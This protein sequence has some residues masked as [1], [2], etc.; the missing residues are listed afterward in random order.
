ML[1]LHF[2]F[3]VL[4]SFVHLSLNMLYRNYRIL[5]YLT[6]FILR[7]KE[8]FLKQDILVSIDYLPSFLLN[9][10]HLI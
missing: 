7:K 10:P 5:M 2:E 1:L 3:S 8:F 6:V 4:S 9:F